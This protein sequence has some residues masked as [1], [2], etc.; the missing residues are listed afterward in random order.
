M[1]VV[2]LL[3]FCILCLGTIPIAAQ[4]KIGENPTSIQPGSLLELESLSK[5]LRLPR[6]PLNDVHVWTLDGTA[7]SGM[8]II[9]E[10]GTA[11]KGIYYWSTDQLQWVRIVNSSELS[12]L[13]TA[14]TTVSNTSTGNNLTTTVNGVTG[15]GVTIINNN[16]L[17]VANGV[18][19]STVNGV[20]STGVN[21]LTSADNGLSTTNGKVQLGGTLVQPTNIE[22]GANNMSVT[23]NSTGNLGIFQANPDKQLHIGVKVDQIKIDTL[24]TLNSLNESSDYI[25]VYQKT[26]SGNA[27]IVKKVPVS[28]LTNNATELVKVFTLNVEGM[29]GGGATFSLDFSGAQ[30]G[31]QVIANAIT[32]PVAPE[33]D[34]GEDNGFGIAN[35]YVSSADKVAIRVLT[36]QRLQ[37]T[38][39]IRVLVKK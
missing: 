39:D 23:S 24:T 8:I 22:L 18:L 16:S 28:T 17:N 37:G 38:V 5:G 12:S 11:P 6:I 33:L 13:I 1:K 30:L 3:F 36:P 34:V 29:M 4:N 14:G 32:Q 2:R 9:N 21:V 15:S 27:G 7:V 19:T 20:A 35:A 25:L 26:G 10:N 31:N